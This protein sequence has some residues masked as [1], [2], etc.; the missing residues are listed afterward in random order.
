LIQPLRP[1]AMAMLRS[2]GYAVYRS[3]E[4]ARMIQS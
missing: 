2:C 4:S 3:E 1:E